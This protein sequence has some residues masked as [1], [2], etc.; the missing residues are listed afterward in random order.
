MKREAQNYKLVDEHVRI[1]KVL[2]TK[3]NAKCEFGGDI[4]EDIDYYMV[5]EYAV[6]QSLLS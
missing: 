6:C 5:M 4:V 1:I 2:F 3:E